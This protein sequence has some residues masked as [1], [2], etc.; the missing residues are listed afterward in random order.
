MPG[1]VAFWD[2][3]G[4]C[5][6]NLAVSTGSGVSVLLSKGDGIATRVRMRARGRQLDIDDGPR[7]PTLRDPEDDVR[8]DLA[9]R[10][11]AEQCVLDLPPA[12]RCDRARPG[13]L[14]AGARNEEPE[15]RRLGDEARDRAGRDDV[16]RR[17]GR[18]RC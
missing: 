10:L 5:K 11:S 7:H 17:P 2:F 6:I 15:R 16:D 8:E 13:D 1:I 14:A 18:L 4:D 9:T 12:E 3:D